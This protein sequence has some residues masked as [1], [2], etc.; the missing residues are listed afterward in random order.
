MVGKSF[1]FSSSLGTETLN[2]AICLSSITLQFYRK[3]YL[4]CSYFVL[5]LV[6]FVAQLIESCFPLEGPNITDPYL[7]ALFP[8][9]SHSHTYA[10]MKS[11]TY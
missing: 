3:I 8:F 10:V 4:H 7:P 11:S 1:I 6:V 5:I 9:S 2:H